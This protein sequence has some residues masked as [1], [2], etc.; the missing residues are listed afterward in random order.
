V[1]AH[2]VHP[3]GIK[4]NIVRSSRFVSSPTADSKAQMVEE[5]DRFL[6]RTS[7]DDCA[8]T[9]VGGVRRGKERILV[10]ADARFIDRIAR[11]TPE[12]YV[13][14]FHAAQMRIANRGRK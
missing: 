9:I 3:G 14:L 13:S 4:T 1:H 5:F 2:T 8:R 6:A 12:K 10:G 7:P 11:L